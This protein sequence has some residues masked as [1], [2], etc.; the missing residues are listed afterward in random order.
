MPWSFA[1]LLFMVSMVL[2]GLAAVVV[3]LLG[4]LVVSRTAVWLYRGT[5]SDYL[6]SGSGVISKKEDK[7]DQD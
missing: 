4:A 5:Y 7:H 1:N 3:V 2:Q 6:R